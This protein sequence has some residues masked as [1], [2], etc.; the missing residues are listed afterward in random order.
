TERFLQYR[1]SGT[2]RRGCSRRIHKHQGTALG[3]NRRSG[4]SGVRAEPCISNARAP[5]NRR[6]RD[7]I[8]GN[9]ASFQWQLWPPARVRVVNWNIDRGLKLSAIVDFLASQRADLITLQE[10]DLNAKRT[11]HLN[12]AEEIAR[13]LEMNYVFGR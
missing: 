2:R 4:R 11:H 9:F 8:G 10:A 6:M 13:R 12:I 7:I 5:S 3:R 1:G